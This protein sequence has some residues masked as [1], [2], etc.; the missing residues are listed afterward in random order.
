[1]N[2]HDL[3]PDS[4][5]ARKVLDKLWSNVTKE[6]NG[7]ID[8][9]I[10]QLIKSKFVS[11]RYCLP[12]QLLGK[13]LDHKRDCLCL[14]KGS[15]DEETKWD[16]RSFASKV[17]VPWI[18]DN[19]NVLGTS[20]DPYVS[21]PLRKPSLEPDPGNVKG[22]REWELL[23]E[24]LSDVQANDSPEYTHLKMLQ[25]LRSINSVLADYK[26][27]YSIPQRISLMQCE[28]IVAEFLADASGGD[29][30]L[31]LAAALFETFGK[32]FGLYQEVRRHKINTSDQATGSAGD[33]ECL[34]EDGNIRLAVEVKERN[35]SLTDIRSSVRKARKVSLKE[36]FLNSPGVNPTDEDEVNKLI[37]RTWA[38]GT[39]IYLLSIDELVKVGLALVGEE[40]RIDF[41]RNVGD[42]LDKYNTQPANR[43]R[44]KELLELL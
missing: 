26:F 22:K 28:E 1:M 20:T 16:P 7:D 17:I 4:A 31:S 40:G 44:W 6:T 14:Q 18:A 8:P 29:R 3:A 27:E 12:T 33:I 2:E 37:S 39:N 5:D 35:V 41:I 9:Q 15:G 21:K 32:S 38:S 25:T 30:G 13:L 34:D 10:D 19:Q 36:F 42:Q 24:V 23:Y 43:L 11:I